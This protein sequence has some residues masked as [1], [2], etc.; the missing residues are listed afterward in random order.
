M[1][2]HNLD[3]HIYIHT[4]IHTCMHIYI[5]HTHTHTHTDIMCACTVPV[6]AGSSLEVKRTDENKASYLRNKAM[7]RALECVV[8]LSRFYFARRELEPTQPRGGG[9]GMCD[10]IGRHTLDAWRHEYN[11]YN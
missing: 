8:Q 10:D 9:G 2:C 1:L 4:Y 3:I 11:R 6:K 7:S 5:H